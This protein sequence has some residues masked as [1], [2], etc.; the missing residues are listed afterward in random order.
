[1]G[2]SR[3]KKFELIGGLS[4]AAIAYGGVALGLAIGWFRFG[5]LLLVITVP[6]GVVLGWVMAEGL[7][8]ASKLLNDEA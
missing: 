6:L 8:F 1:V 5:V 4:G 3:E 2:L 7:K